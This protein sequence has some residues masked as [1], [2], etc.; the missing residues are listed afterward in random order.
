MN[1]PENSS[2]VLNYIHCC[3]IKMFPIVIN[4]NV[5]DSVYHNTIYINR[6]SASFMKTRFRYKYGQCAWQIF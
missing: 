5:C 6:I 3:I 4:Y 1:I 2:A